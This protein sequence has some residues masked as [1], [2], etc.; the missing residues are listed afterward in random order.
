MV[1]C[2]RTYQE[3][4]IGQESVEEHA[5]ANPPAG[6]LATVQ[7]LGYSDGDDDADK[8]VAG[9]CDQ[10]VKLRIVRDTQQVAAQLETEDLCH[11]YY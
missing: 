2:G 1:T 4:R 3:Q 7:D 11:D 6:T 5:P 10:V 8:L 9:V